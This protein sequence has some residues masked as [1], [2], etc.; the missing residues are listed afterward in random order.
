MNGAQL[1]PRGQR[2]A[3]GTGVAAAVLFGGWAVRVG[4]TARGPLSAGA[5]A[6]LAAFVVAG[7]RVEWTR[8]PRAARVALGALALF[9]A[10]SFL[11]IAW[12]GARGEAWEAA[13]RVLI[14]LTVFALFAVL[15]WTATQATG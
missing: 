4:G 3:A 11:S 12:A 10:W 13:D 1:A 8:L 5:L 15:P 7:R 6:L 14:Y 2:A 9:A